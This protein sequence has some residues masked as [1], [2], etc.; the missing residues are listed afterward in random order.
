[1]L[2]LAALAACSTC[3]A[4][5]RRARLAALIL[6]KLSWHDFFQT[7]TYTVQVLLIARL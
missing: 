2:L 4:A 5:I 6:S 3:T 7:C 1:M